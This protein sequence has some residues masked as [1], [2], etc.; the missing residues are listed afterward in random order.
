MSSLRMS[1]T[2]RDSVSPTVKIDRHGSVVITMGKGYDV[3]STPL[4]DG[5]RFQTPPLLA[6]PH[7]PVHSSSKRSTSAII[8]DL[9]SP[10][11]LHAVDSVHEK[12][13]SLIDKQQHLAPDICIGD[14]S[15]E[16]ASKS[17]ICVSL[18]KKSNWLPELLC[19]VVGLD[20]FPREP[21]NDPTFD[22]AIESLNLAAANCAKT[23]LQFCWIIMAACIRC[24]CNLIAMY[25]R[26]PTTPRRI[27]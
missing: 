20:I 22:A 21:V 19:S 5:N 16:E 18:A 8:A 4:D 26:R 13:Q 17:N 15:H 27:C 2:T 10:G 7:A 11:F 9:K 1:K 6:S 25:R 14:L 23:I 12:M 24:F 3:S